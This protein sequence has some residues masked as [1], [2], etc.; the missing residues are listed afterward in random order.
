MNRSVIVFIGIFVLLASCSQAPPATDAQPPAPPTNVVATS[1]PGFNRISW[2][3][4]GSEPQNFRIYRQVANDAAAATLSAEPLGSVP[5]AQRSFDDDSAQVGQP[6][7]YT[8]SALDENGV[9]STPA[10]QSGPPTE[11]FGPTVDN[12]PEFQAAVGTHNTDDGVMTYFEVYTK[13]VGEGENVT[14]RIFGP[15]GWNDGELWEFDGRSG[16]SWIL[17]VDTPAVSGVFRFSTVI[18]GTIYTDSMLLDAEQTLGQVDEIRITE[19]STNRIAF[20]WDPPDRAHS[21]WIFLTEKD[22]TDSVAFTVVNRGTTSAEFT[23]LE[24]EAGRPYQI[25][26]NAFSPA[27]PRTPEAFTLQ[28]DSSLSLSEPFTLSEGQE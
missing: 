20:E 1:N 7:I 28:I 6:Y 26:I 21:F 8:V 2:E 27:P 5:G 10:A 22:A 23:G 14:F 24:L 4:D 19:L 15:D 3:Y 9:E 11:P 13:R 17:P 16:V 18:D 12:A 25:Q